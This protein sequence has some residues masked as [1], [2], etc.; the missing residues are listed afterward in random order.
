METMTIREAIKMYP[1]LLDELVTFGSLSGGG[2]PTLR[3]ADRATLQFKGDG[4]YRTKELSRKTKE[5]AR[6]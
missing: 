6:R 3:T 2:R 5:G 4:G 1:G